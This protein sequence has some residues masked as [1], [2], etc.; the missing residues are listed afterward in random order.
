MYSNKRTLNKSELSKTVR[1]L[2]ATNSPFTLNRLREVSVILYDSKLSKQTLFSLHYTDPILGKV[3]MAERLIRN[4]ST[5]D[6][7]IIGVVM[8]EYE[9]VPSNWQSI[10][11]SA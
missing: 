10:E 11:Y 1:M 7:I 2:K 9:F 4:N 5:T 3:V 6:D 8:P